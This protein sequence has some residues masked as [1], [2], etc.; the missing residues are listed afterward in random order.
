MLRPPLTINAP[1]F[2]GA[3]MLDSKP[4]IVTPYLKNGNARVYLENNLDCN[5]LELVC[6]DLSLYLE[7][8]LQMTM[9]AISCL[10]GPDASSLQ[11]Y[12][13]WRS[14]SG[15]ETSIRALLVSLMCELL[16]LN[17]LID[18]TGKAV[19][20]DFGLS[21]M[22]DDIASRANVVDVAAV[23]G[24]RNWMAPERL[25]GGALKKHCDIYAF[26]MVIYEVFSLRSVEDR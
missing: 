14:Q 6:C 12:R 21:R 20:C 26:G 7:E 16:K 25:I 9:S 24:S 2:Y 1:A 22:K 23:A 8:N 17:I 11:E 5:R 10:S 19:L 4:F 18:D 15:N 3:N 13:T